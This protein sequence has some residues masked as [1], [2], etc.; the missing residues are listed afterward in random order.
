MAT[1]IQL[2]QTRSAIGTTEAVRA[3][4]KGLGLTGPRSKKTLQDTPAIRGMILKVQHLV[5]VVVVDGAAPKSGQ[6]HRKAK[7]A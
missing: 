7:K 4:L 6:R 1:H 5:D 2:T 3:T